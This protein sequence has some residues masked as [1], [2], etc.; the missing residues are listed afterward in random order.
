MAINLYDT[1]TMLEAK[2][3]FAPKAT[4]LRDRYFPTSEADIFDTEKV[5]IDYE[6]EQSNKIAPA[7]LPEVGGIPVDRRGYETHE[8]E[9]PTIAPERILKPRDLYKRQAGEVIG[10]NLTPQQREAGILA[11]DL[12]DLGRMI[13]LREEQMAAQTLLNNAYTIKQYADKFGSQSIDKAIQF[14]TEGSNPATYS[15][16][17]W[18]T[19][20]TN[21]IADL[22][23]MANRLTK[24]GLPATDVVVAAD[25]ADVMLGNSEVQE[26]LDIRRYELG[27]VKPEALPEGAVLIAV[28]N[29][30]GHIMNVFSYSLSY[31]DES[32]TTKD[33]IPSG[34]VIVTAPACGRMAYG[35][36]S[37][38]EEGVDGF[39]TYAGRRVPH[40][41]NNVH[42]NVRTLTLQAKPLAIPNVKNPFVY[43]KVL[44]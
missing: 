13:D 30:K 44:S 28:L 34:S 37:Q 43:S 27:Q 9:P 26:L 20:S 12:S 10:G 38:L 19:S 14:Y 11:K 1:R 2:E 6:D 22:D 8:F 40:V 33:F 25:V 24:R 21:I 7:I 36:I 32:G 4:F 18:S 29:V 39:V 35:S 41:V 3:V 16:S 5:D 42:D 23:T 17:G 31:T 15:G